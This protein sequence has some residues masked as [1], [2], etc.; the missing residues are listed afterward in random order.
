M[1]RQVDTGVVV[2]RRMRAAVVAA[3]LLRG[4]ALTIQGAR[5]SDVCKRKRRRSPLAQKRSIRMSHEGLT[6]LLTM[7]AI[8]L[9][10]IVIACAFGK[11]KV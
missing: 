5:G 10:L 7:I 6:Q 4:W 2:R 1:R 8:V 9:F 3:E 11:G